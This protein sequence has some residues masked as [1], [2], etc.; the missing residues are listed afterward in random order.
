M[1]TGAVIYARVSTDEQAKFGTSI[2][3][4]LEKCRNYANMQI[5]ELLPSLSTNTSALPWTIR[6]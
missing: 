3:A 6:D 5:S 1:N 2:E 4:Q